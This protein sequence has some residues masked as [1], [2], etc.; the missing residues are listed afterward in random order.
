[1]VGSVRQRLIAPAWQK[2]TPEY[3]LPAERKSTDRS[4]IITRRGGSVW[5]REMEMTRD[6]RRG[7]EIIAPDNTTVV[8][9]LPHR[10]RTVNVSC[11]LAIALADRTR[12]VG[13]LVHTRYAERYAEP[14]HFALAAMNSQPEDLCVGISGV[15]GALGVDE[16][17]VVAG[18]GEFG[19][20]IYDQ[21]GKRGNI[22]IDF[23]ERM[24]YGPHDI[25]YK[26]AEPSFF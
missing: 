4:I 15:V 17:R 11:C 18:I 21:M 23:E 12:L 10:M 9:E 7:L 24:I 2:F 5:V 6:S 1:M 25:Y 26:D 16:G 22:A 14:L 3:C 8:S 19:Q 13:A 20:I